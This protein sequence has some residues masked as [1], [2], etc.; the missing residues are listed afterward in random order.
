MEKNIDIDIEILDMLDKD[1][2][3]TPADIAVML[4][5]EEAEVSSRIAALRESGV[6]VGN[7]TLINWNRSSRETVTALIELKVT[8]QFGRGFDQIAERF[9]QYDQVKSV[10]LMSGAYDLA[11]Q[12]EGRN[13]REVA[14]FVAEKLAP[15]DAVVST[16]THF[17][18]KKYKEDGMM[19]EGPEKEDTR[20]VIH[21]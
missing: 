20:Q 19:F 14:L 21:I 16:A 13:L 4:G 1:S 10:Y 11:L 6:I 12:I 18:L 5:V 3:L 2:S 9:Y 15:M 7:K 17:V 8:P